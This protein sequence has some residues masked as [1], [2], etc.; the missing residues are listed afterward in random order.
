MNAAPVFLDT[1]ALLALVHAGDSHHA[2]VLAVLRR[3]ERKAVPLV[4]HSYVLVET[5]ALVRKRFGNAPFRQVAGVVERSATV[6]WVDA[7]LHREAW[8]KAAG[9][10]RDGPG[11]VDWVSFLVMR[12]LS[13]AT[14]VTLDKHF[15][16]EGF[17]I[18]P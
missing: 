15:R 14:A 11:L 1:S 12:R 3:L 9:T 5:G 4:T 7:R 17:R 10:G 6:S 16:D 2:D 18:L 8:D 13:I